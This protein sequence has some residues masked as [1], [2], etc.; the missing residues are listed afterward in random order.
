M[1]NRT[2]FS[3]KAEVLFFAFIFIALLILVAPYFSFPPISDC[4]ILLH[5]FHTLDELP[6][7]GNGHWQWLHV[8]NWDP[9]EQMNYRPLFGL[10]YYVPFAIFARPH[11]FYNVFNFLLYFFSVIVLYRFS[12]I[13][14]KDRLLAVS[15]AGIFAFL[16]S[17]FDILL[18]SFH[19]HIIL[20]LSLFFLAF[21]KYSKFL[22]EG[23]ASDLILTGA[24]F[25][26]GLFC[27][28]PLILWPLGI[29]MLSLQPPRR[30]NA[31]GGNKLLKSN[32]QLL[33]GVYCPYVAAYFL[34]RLLN[35]YPAA[36]R[37]WEEFFRVK[38]IVFAFCS[39]M[40]NVL[41]TAALNFNPRLMFPLEAVNNLYVSG[42]IIE[43]LRAGNGNLIYGVGAGV[44]A[45]LFF[46]SRR[47]IRH[48]RKREL[49]FLSFLMFLGM[50]EIFVLSFCRLA[51]N[52]FYY[53]FT[54]SRYNYIINAVF[55][56][57][58]AVLFE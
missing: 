31:K 16:S 58:G 46:F 43:Y 13:F 10:L 25:I 12:L 20:G 48:G 1:E 42:P 8:V 5:F 37:H 28:E 54:E 38:N 17:H 56:V 3:R 51:T 36:G 6:K 32:L 23:K 49:R 40:F 47:L 55:V 9:N 41:F 33:A 53:V 19:M 34:T 11:I 30:E 21:I 18:W 27:Y 7:I 35:T 39:S 2:Y 14:I 57:A 4:W 24:L 22:E 45:A 44:V 29:F 50:S 15:C 52:K 26:A